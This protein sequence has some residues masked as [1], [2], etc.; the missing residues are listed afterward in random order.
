VGGND[1]WLA[2]PNEVVEY[3]LNERTP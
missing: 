1:V 2:E 3:L